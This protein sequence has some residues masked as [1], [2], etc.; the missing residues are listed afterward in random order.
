MLLIIKL[1]RFPIFQFGWLQFLEFLLN[2]SL[3]NDS[4]AYHVLENFVLYD[5]YHAI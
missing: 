3:I 1:Y 2:W 4:L 5:I